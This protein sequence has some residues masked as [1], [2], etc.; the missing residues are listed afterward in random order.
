[1]RR[2]FFYTSM[3]KTRGM[4]TEEMRFL[5]A[6]A[7]YRLMNRKRIEDIREEMGIMYEGRFRSS[8]THIIIPSRKF[9]EVR[10]RSLFRSISHGKRC[11]SYNTPPTSRKRAADR[12]PLRYFLPRSSLFMIGKAQKSQEA[13]SGL[14]GGCCKGVP[15][16]HFFQAEH[17]IQ[18]KSRPV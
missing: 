13:R 8:W 7:D 10:W 12:W 2:S 11:T 5:R 14:Y 1:M 4:E 18:F 15:P 17:R 16:I 3:L 9:V 6:V